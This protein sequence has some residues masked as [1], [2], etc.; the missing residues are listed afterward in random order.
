MLYSDADFGADLDGDF[1]K[2]FG[3]RTPPPSPQQ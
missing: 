3:T 2:V 1:K